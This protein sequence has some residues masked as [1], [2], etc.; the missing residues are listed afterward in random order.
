MYRHA[1]LR[2]RWREWCSATVERPK[3]LKVS[4]RLA[5]RVPVPVL[6]LGIR[7]SCDVKLWLR[8]VRFFRN[9]DLERFLKKVSLSRISRPS[10]TEQHTSD[11]CDC[12]IH[13]TGL[14]SKS[15]LRPSRGRSRLMLAKRTARPRVHQIADQDAAPQHDFPEAVIER[16]QLGQNWNRPFAALASE[17]SHALLSGRSVTQIGPVEMVR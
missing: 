13:K 17:V 6:C 7:I 10:K 16:R 2:I 4:E 5:Y 12:F 14:W 1:L 9:S 15:R 3:C 11:H 8:G